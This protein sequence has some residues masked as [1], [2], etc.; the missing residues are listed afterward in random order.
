MRKVGL[1]FGAAMVAAGLATANPAAAQNV[2]AGVDAWGRGDFKA[3]VE[4]WR[5]PALAGDADAQFNLGQAYKLGR[6]VPLDPALAESWFR[7]A[8][9][10]GHYQ[11]E[12]NYGLA[13]FTAGRKSEAV[14]W[15]EKSVARGEPRGQLVLGTMLFNG[16]G[17]PRDYPRAYAL[18]TRASQAGLKS[19]SETLA[20]MDQYISPEDREKGVRLAQQY[21]AMP[22]PLPQAGPPRQVAASDAPPPRMPPGA[23]PGGPQRIP[24]TTGPARVPAPREPAPQ[25]AAPRAVEPRPAPVRT[26]GGWHIQLGAFSSQSNAAAQWA[27]VRGRLGGAQPTYARAGSVIRLQAGGYGSKGEAQRACSASGVACVVVAP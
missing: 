14:P 26:A 1:M 5:G 17:V 18:M 11:A 19:A 4:Q 22:R 20:Q 2:K 21:A 10:Q 13:L 25:A 12:D 23:R 7:K 3:A 24:P 15:L 6:G 8:A 27:K 9:L 16:D